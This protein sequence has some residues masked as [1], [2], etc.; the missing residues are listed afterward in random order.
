MTWEPGKE[1]RTRDGR[2][3]RVYALDGGGAHPMHGAVYNH[4]SGAWEPTSWM[5]CGGYLHAKNDI[6]PRDIMPPEPEKRVVYFNAYA[7]GRFGLVWDSRSEADSHVE[8][9][10]IACIRVEFTEGQ[11]DD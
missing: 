4:G 5:S 9:D 6:S 11:F 2:R 8:G 7:D 10:R 3:A 1:Y